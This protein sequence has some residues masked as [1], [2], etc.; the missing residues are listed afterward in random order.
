[1]DDSIIA[2]D[3]IIEETFPTNLNEK[4]ANYKMQNYDI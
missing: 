2:C 4:K 1:M 3:G